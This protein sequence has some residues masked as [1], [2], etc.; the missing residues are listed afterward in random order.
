[1]TPPTTV[2]LLCSC[3]DPMS[4]ALM[5]PVLSNGPGLEFDT[6]TPPHQCCL[7]PETPQDAHWEMSL[8]LIGI[9]LM[10]FGLQ[11]NMIQA[12]WQIG[13]NLKYGLVFSIYLLLDFPS[14][15]RQLTCAV[16]ICQWNNVSLSCLN[17][18]FWGLCS[19]EMRLFLMQYHPKSG[20]W[21]GVMDSCV[22]LH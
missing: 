14:T 6:L 10:S 7:P 12:F 19:P 18:V 9:S 20:M 16:R 8:L 11:K 15:L 22:S 21:R 5:G 13:D 4:D 2:L 1:M 17:E 3:A